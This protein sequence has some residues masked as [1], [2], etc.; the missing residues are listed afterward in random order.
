MRTFHSALS[1][2][3][4]WATFSVALAQQPVF[5]IETDIHFGDSKAPA[6]QTLTLFSE[7][8]YYDF[9]LDDHTAITLVDPQRNRIVL[10]DA[11]RNIQTTLDTTEMYSTSNP[12]GSKRTRL[13]LQLLL[14]AADQVEFDDATGVCSVGI[15]QMRYVAQSQRPTDPQMAEQYA[16]FANWSARTE[17]CL[18]ASASALFAHEVE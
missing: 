15:A 11:K 17:R 18:S 13:D 4:M 9:S 7:G 2:L 1:A 12:L 10:L 8:V 6:K 5:R 3:F 16:D 14:K